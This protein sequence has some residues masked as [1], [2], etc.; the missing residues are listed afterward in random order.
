MSPT[1]RVIRID[2]IMS[3]LGGPH[4]TEHYVRASPPATPGSN[5]VSTRTHFSSCANVTD[6]ANAVSVE[7]LK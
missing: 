7:G 5:P 3:K 1:L 6:F 4:N 2:I